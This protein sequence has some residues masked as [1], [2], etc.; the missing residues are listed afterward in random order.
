MTW[1]ESCSC[2]SASCSQDATFALT[3]E[4]NVKSG[5][6]AVQYEGQPVS[7][8][9]CTQRGGNG[10]AEKNKMGDGKRGSAL[11]PETTPC[12]IH[13]RSSGTSRRVQIQARRRTRASGELGLRVAALYMRHAGCL[14]LGRVPN[15][16]HQQ[17]AGRVTWYTFESSRV[18]IHQSPAY[19]IVYR[20]HNVCR[21]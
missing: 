13:R 15:G 7:R 16:R 6:M 12:L 11:R 3:A 10:E 20:V 19:C 21:M 14:G 9:R 17:I 18:C 8:D 2:T 4:S 1:L 5:R